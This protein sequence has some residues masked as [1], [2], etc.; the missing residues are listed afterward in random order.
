M[1]MQAQDNLHVPTCYPGL[2]FVAG[3]QKQPTAKK[4]AEVQYQPGA[5]Q[6]SWEMSRQVR[7]GFGEKPKAYCNFNQKELDNL[8]QHE[9]QCWTHA[10]VGMG[11][12]GAR[13]MMSAK[14]HYNDC[15]ALL[16]RVFR[17]GKEEAWGRGPLPGIWEWAEQFIPLLL[18]DLRAKKMD[19][20]EWID[21]MP[22]RR[23]KALRIA[24]IRYFRTGWT[25]GYES[26]KA[27]VKS[28]L[29][30]GFAKRGGDLERLLDMMDR[31]I[32]GPNDVTHVIAG[33]WLKPL[34]KQLKKAWDVE[35]PLFYGSAGPEPLHMFLQKFID[36][37]GTYFWS[38]FTMFDTTHSAQSWRFMRNLYRKAGIDDPD[39]WRVM[40]AWQKP[41]GSI[42]C[43]KYK[44]RVM[45]ASGRDDT[46]LSNAV[47]NG[48][49]TYL[50][51]TSALLCKPLC[52]ITPQDVLRMKDLLQL[53]VCGDDTLGRLPLMGPARSEEFRT[54]M[55]SNLRY[56]GFVA[57][58]DTSD[59]LEDCV[60]LGMRPYPTTQGWFWGK[61][62]GRAS[63]KLG[64]ATIKP[65]RDLFAHMQGIAHMHLLCS[66]HVPVL[67]DIAKRIVE[68]RPGAKVTPVVRDPN[69]PWEWTYQGSVEYD[70]LTLEGV[71]RTYTRR[72][73][74]ID[75]GVTVKDIKELIEQ[76]RG[77]QTIPCIVDHWL[78]K[79]MVFSDDL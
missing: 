8:L 77:V 4:W 44:A 5:V 41:K 24:A 48:F 16:G 7:M 47:L 61:T 1:G 43:F 55:K 45:N 78:W 53:S 30:P 15:K 13:P 68:L 74:D 59:R 40:D 52:D 50:S 2:V 3:E 25:K 31:I 37:A 10:L 67:Y 9:R 38:D 54:L 34:V 28:E 21:S 26:F 6:F 56:F 79:R 64:W 66:K 71:A 39:F 72:F 12:S 22:S 11:C 36:G 63:Y 57:K 33:P 14:T 70:E 18:P 76:I 20:E 46:A 23:R 42:G 51:A 60:Y 65:G 62:I 73:D 19:V 69:K 75:Q 32:Q 27:F 58:L 17:V 35:S 49:A 29:L